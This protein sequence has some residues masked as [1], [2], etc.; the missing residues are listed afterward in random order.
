MSEIVNDE[1]ID[2]LQKGAKGKSIASTREAKLGAP[3]GEI[4]RVAVAIVVLADASAN[5]T[6]Q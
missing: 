2:S 3:G 1:Q 6:C 4:V 5:M